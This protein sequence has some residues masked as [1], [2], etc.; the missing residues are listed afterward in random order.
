MLKRVMQD[1]TL[2]YIEALKKDPEFEAEN[3][4]FAFVGNLVEEIQYIDSERDCFSTSLLES[5]EA[6]TEYKEIIA[7]HVLRIKDLEKPAPQPVKVVDI[8]AHVDLLVSRI[9]S[10]ALDREFDDLDDEVHYRDYL[11]ARFDT[12]LAEIAP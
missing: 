3:I 4:M 8:I 6:I 9:E 7:K 10:D 2:L 12:L 1:F 5:K 11:K